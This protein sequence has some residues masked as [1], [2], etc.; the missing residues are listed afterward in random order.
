MKRRLSS[1]IIDTIIQSL[2]DPKKL[3]EEIENYNIK[4]IN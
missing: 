4:I 3:N 2:I 1:K